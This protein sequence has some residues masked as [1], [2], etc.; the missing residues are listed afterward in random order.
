MAARSARGLSTFSRCP[1]SGAPFVIA[2]KQALLRDPLASLSPFIGSALNNQIIPYGGMQKP[3]AVP[4][5]DDWRKSRNVFT[6]GVAKVNP[7]QDH[8]LWLV[9]C[10]PEKQEFYHCQW[11]VPCISAFAAALGC[12]LDMATGTIANAQLNLNDKQS[13]T[14]LVINSHFLQHDV[15]CGRHFFLTITKVLDCAGPVSSS[16]DESTCLYSSTSFL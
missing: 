9:D 15:L 4:T 6:K 1:D 12:N 3:L 10:L 8:E 16:F 7:L 14:I 2:Y 13:V 11:F 5:G